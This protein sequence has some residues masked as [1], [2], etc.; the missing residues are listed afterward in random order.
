MWEGHRR[1]IASSACCD[2]HVMYGEF[3][4]YAKD[5]QLS[6][7][8]RRVA[9]SRSGASGTSDKTS[10]IAGGVTYGKFVI[11]GAVCHVWMDRTHAPRGHPAPNT[12]AECK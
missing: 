3:V 12:P 10:L 9:A 2:P 7:A 6:T 11:Y 1:D 4:I 5:Q 8:T